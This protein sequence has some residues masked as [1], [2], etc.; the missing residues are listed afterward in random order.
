MPGH[1]LQT[2]P[3]EIS[4]GMWTCGSPENRVGLHI[5][6]SGSVATGSIGGTYPPTPVRPGHGNLPKSEEKKMEVGRVPGRLGQTNY[7]QICILVTKYI[8]KMNKI[9]NTNYMPCI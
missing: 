2:P 6:S 5:N 8:L 9:Q 7:A 3:I 4:F 1:C